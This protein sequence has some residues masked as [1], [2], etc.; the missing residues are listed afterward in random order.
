MLQDGSSW[1]QPMRR[2]PALP[3][4]TARPTGRTAQ[5]P[6]A[7]TKPFNG[8]CGQGALATHMPCELWL[9]YCIEKYAPRMGRSGRHSGCAHSTACSVRPY[10]VQRERDQKIVVWVVPCTSLFSPIIHV[11]DILTQNRAKT[12]FEPASAHLHLFLSSLPFRTHTTSCARDS[13]ETALGFCLAYSS[14]YLARVLVP[15]VSE[16]FSAVD[17]F[18][19]YSATAFAVDS[20]GYSVLVHV[21]WILTIQ[22]TCASA[23]D[24]KR[25]QC[26]CITRFLWEKLP[27]AIFFSSFLSFLP[28]P[29]PICS[30]TCVL[31]LTLVLSYQSYSNFPPSGFNEVYLLHSCSLCSQNTP[32]LRQN[33][34]G[35]VYKKRME[36]VY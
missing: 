32:H 19:E 1:R 16:N 30:S 22:R 24:P 26:T 33:A 25:L 6:A 7:C 34:R 14:W 3:D 15:C 17:S 35:G 21:R 4:C 23:V 8:P 18:L 31:L 28:C 20:H 10:C 36:T 5:P 9:H 11:W 2:R 27:C 13:I 29:P 12:G